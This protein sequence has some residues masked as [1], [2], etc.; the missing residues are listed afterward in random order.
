[1]TTRSF[2]RRLARHFSLSTPWPNGHMA[3]RWFIG[4]GL[5]GFLVQVIPRPAGWPLAFLFAEDGQV[6]LTDALRDGPSSL[7][8]TYAGYLLFFPRA[9]AL[10][11]SSIFP[12]DVYVL[13]TGSATGLVKV[14]AVAIA[15]PVL[16]AYARSWAWG[17]AASASFL[18]IP[19][20]NLEVLG[21]IT[22]LRWFLVAGAF[23]ALLGSFR[24]GWLALIAAGFTFAAS[25]SDP[26]AL[27]WLPLA[28]WRIGGERS[29]ARLPGA[30]ALLGAIVQLFYLQPEARGERGTAADLIAQPL[31]TVAQLLIRGPVATQYG[32]SWT[33]EFLRFGVLPTLVTLALTALVVFAAWKNRRTFPEA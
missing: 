9:I 15:W 8:E 17:L 11:C 20:G 10:S 31:D 6:F 30:A 26:L 25:T 5:V 7:L 33:Q 16:T 14:V 22:N 27:A 32:M 12:P 19:V 1:M 3:T 4:V 2:I 21:N 23:F 29:W 18:F 13:C 24:T 28:L